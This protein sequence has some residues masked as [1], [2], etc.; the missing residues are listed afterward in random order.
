MAFWIEDYYNRERRHSTIGY[1]SPID[2]EQEFIAA[3]TLNP[4]NS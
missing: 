2:Y 3:R 4:V 1:L